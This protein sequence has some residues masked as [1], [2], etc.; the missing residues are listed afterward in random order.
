MKGAAV[1]RVTF[2]DAKPL[3]SKKGDPIELIQVNSIW[4]EMLMVIF[5]RIVKILIYLT[6]WWNLFLFIKCVSN[7]SNECR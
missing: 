4:E 5:I 2:K 1:K 3:K 6:Y 7:K